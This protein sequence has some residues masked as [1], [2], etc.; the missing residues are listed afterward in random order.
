MKT[1]LPGQ[2]FRLDWNAA[3]DLGAED[4]AY[5]DLFRVEAVGHDWVIL[6][7]QGN[8]MAYSATFRDETDKDLFMQGLKKPDYEF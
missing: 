2:P 3:K 1:L 5:Y 8:G 4:K 7:C 6:R